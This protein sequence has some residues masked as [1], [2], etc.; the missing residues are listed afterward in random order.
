M[1][2]REKP[3]KMKSD[4]VAQLAC[5]FLLLL[6]C[7]TQKYV[8]PEKFS[9]IHMLQKICKQFENTKFIFSDKGMKL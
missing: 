4:V 5:V 6:P 2:F 3:V 7:V 9:E 1:N 8:Y